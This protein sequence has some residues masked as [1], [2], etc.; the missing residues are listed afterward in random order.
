MPEREPAIRLVGEDV[1][2]SRPGLPDLVDHE[3]VVG[4]DLAR[5]GGDETGFTILER[6]GP[7]F[8]VNLV[9]TDFT[10]FEKAARRMEILITCARDRIS[11]EV[12]MLQRRLEYP[13]GRKARSAARRL[14]ALSWFISDAD[15]DGEPNTIPPATQDELREQYAPVDVVYPPDE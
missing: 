9:T 6:T 13:G 12:K 1:V 4:V 2:L 8:S 10:L 5:S 3:Y 14:A 7:K 15:L 11:Q